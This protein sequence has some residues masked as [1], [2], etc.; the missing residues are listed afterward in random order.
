MLPEFQAVPGF[1]CTHIYQV[2]TTTPFREVPLSPCHRGKSKFR[3]VKEFAQGHSAHDIKANIGPRSPALESVLLTFFP[4][5][6]SS[7]KGGSAL[8]VGRVV[9]LAPA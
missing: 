7:C 3:E 6:G 5:W 4:L 8:G 9:L 2:L 1:T